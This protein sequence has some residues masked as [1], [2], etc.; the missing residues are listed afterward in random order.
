MSCLDLCELRVGL[1]NR[2]ETDE[3][4]LMVLRT[5]NVWLLVGMYFSI[6]S[7]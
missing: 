4:L 1:Q 7:L 2:H 3:S 5:L 6:G